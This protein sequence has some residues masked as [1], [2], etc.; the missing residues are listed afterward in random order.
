MTVPVGFVCSSVLPMAVWIKLA[1]L[2]LGSPLASNV[3]TIGALLPVNTLRFAGSEESVILT[4]N[5]S[6]LSRFSFSKSMRKSGR[7]VA[8]SFGATLRRV[9][10]LK[11]VDFS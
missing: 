1:R 11:S 8:S 7:L 5:W 10:D 4:R 9:G 6:E 3:T 2:D